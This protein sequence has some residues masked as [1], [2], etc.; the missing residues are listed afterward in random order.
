LAEPFILVESPAGYGKSFLLQEVR[1]KLE[2]SG[3]CVCFVDLSSPTHIDDEQVLLNLI[4]SKL[5]QKTNPPQFAASSANLTRAAIIGRIS[6]MG[7]PVALIIDTAEKIMDRKLVEWLRDEFVYEAERTTRINVPNAKF[8]CIVAGR[9]IGELWRDPK[10]KYKPKHE[11]FGDPV[12]LTP[13]TFKVIMDTLDAL[14][15]MPDKPRESRLAQQALRHVARGV[16]TIGGGHPGCMLD[17]L[18]EIGAETGYSLIASYFEEN[19]PTLFKRHIKP[20]C[21]AIGR[22]LPENGRDVFPYLCIF[23][24][25]DEDIVRRSIELCKEESLPIESKPEDAGKILSSLVR[26]RVLVRHPEKRLYVDDVIRRVMTVRLK[27][28]KPELIV[29]LNKHALDW[30]AQWLQQPPRDDY[31][32][33]QASI[34]EYLYHLSVDLNLCGTPF[35]EAARAFREALGKHLFGLKEH[36]GNLISPFEMWEIFKSL[37]E[38]L[39]ADEEIHGELAN[40]TVR[41]T[42]E[43]LLTPLIEDVDRLEPH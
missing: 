38:S 22:S 3:W 12:R 5:P 28:E 30:Y 16:Q 15:T 43:H 2:A 20:V 10:S 26:H 36:F 13:F 9:Y 4:A 11:S 41:Y 14:T 27:I 37:L 6:L 40:I 29:R 35:D 8:R 24:C 19:G 34:L 23:R 1:E 42:F 18:L 32:H 21:E 39:R 17:L 7:K 33:Y 31:V 25:Y